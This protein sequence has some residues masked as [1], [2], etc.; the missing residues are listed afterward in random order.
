MI[1]VVFL[2]LS[3]AFEIVNRKILI[4]KLEGF[5]IKKTAINW[6]K[7]YL[8][9]RTQRVKFNE[10]LS[11]PI[12]V[13]VGVPQGSVLGPLLFLLYIYDLNETI[14]DKCKIRLF[15]DD[16]VIYTE[17]YSSYEINDQ[18]NVQMKKIEE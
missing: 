1:D 3:R 10:V 15:T 8:E 2:D 13:N 12:E 16:A 11:S 4:K 7:S 14:G 17:G 6:F 9:G 5:G 18:L